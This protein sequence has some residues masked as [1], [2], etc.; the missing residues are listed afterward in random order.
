LN[1][2]GWLKS[3]AV[4]EEKQKYITAKCDECYRSNCCKLLLA[5]ER[6]NDGLF[7]RKTIQEFLRR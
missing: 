6:W 7:M 2:F 5:I 3:V 1:N 4:G